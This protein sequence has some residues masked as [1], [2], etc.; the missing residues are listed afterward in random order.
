MPNH[1]K[2]PPVNNHGPSRGGRRGAG[3]FTLIEVMVTV[4][5]IAILAAIALPSYGDYMRRGQLPEAFTFLSDFKVKME[6]YYQDNR[7]YGNAAC[8]DTNPPTWSGFAPTS[9]KYFGFTCA[10]TNGGQG[11][12]L[13]ATGN[14]G[15]AT[16]HAYTL[17]SANTKGTTVFKGN[18]VNKTGCWLVNGSEC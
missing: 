12:T 16:G 2:P 3:G 17:D 1:L 4:T 8:A 14:S 13:T 15:R 11:F 5:I 10:L 6:Q 9:A 7:S 18:T